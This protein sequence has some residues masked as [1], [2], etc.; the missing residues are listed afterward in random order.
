MEVLL[1]KQFYNKNIAYLNI[2]TA[3]CAQDMIC[4]E[5]AASLNS[6]SHM[7]KSA[8]RVP[9]MTFPD[10][11]DVCLNVHSWLEYDIKRKK[12]ESTVLK[13]VLCPKHKFT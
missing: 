3:N 2:A 11:P 8:Y 7:S 1:P 13:Y 12:E 10:Q 5:R 9:F 6:F 4:Q